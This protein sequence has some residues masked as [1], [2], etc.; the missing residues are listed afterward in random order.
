ML[1]PDWI[2]HGILNSREVFGVISLNLD[3]DLFILYGTYGTCINLH[4]ALKFH[5][6]SM[7][8]TGWLPIL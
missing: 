6:V 1:L 4:E 7:T 2:V 3:D 8:C 5:G